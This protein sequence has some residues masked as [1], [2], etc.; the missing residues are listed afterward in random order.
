MATLTTASAAESDA[1]EATGSKLSSVAADIAKLG[2]GTLLAALFNVALVFVVPRLISVE[3]YGY[4]KLFGLYAGYV[5]FLHFGYADGALVRWAGRTW[6]DFHHE[7]RPALN[8][9]FWQHVI[10]LVPLCLI[11]ALVL[12]G[13]LRFAIIAVAVYSL[14]MNEA[15]LLQFGL[16]DAK[17]FWPVAISTAAPPAIFFG[18]ILLWGL[19]W[20]SDYRDVTAFYIA[21]W[22]MVLVF[23]LI[24][25]KPWSGVRVR[26]SAKQQAKDWLRIGWPIVVANT[27]VCL[28]QFADRIAVSWAATI[29]NFAQYSL[30][31]SA[32]AVP[33]TAIA[34]CSNVFF[35]HLAGVTSGGRKR[36]YRLSSRLILIAWAALLPYYF[37]L[38][39]FVGHFLPKYTASLQYAR[40]LLL[41]MPF[42]A[43]VQ[44]L[45][46][47]LAYLSG[48]QRSFLAQTLA[49]LVLS[50]GITSFVA[51][52][53]GSL[54][55][56][57]AAQVGILAAWWL[58]NEWNL[59]DLTDGY[60]GG[61]IGFF[62]IY[63]VASGCYW[64]VTGWTGQP[65]VLLSLIYY[66]LFGVLL[67]VAG[68]EEL[69]SCV[70]VV[71]VKMGL[72]RDTFVG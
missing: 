67:S 12:H 14:I 59:R 54:R 22:L 41:G 4:W 24:W 38:D 1:R 34:A 18:V 71:L 55:V 53:V 19:K 63:G 56:V 42:L 61:W 39:I 26:V 20:R 25:T 47:N 43:A 60:F 17:I 3:D 10:M 65:A 21:G 36:M 68:P 50:V 48:R 57:A 8:Y 33:I 69:R 7:I 40:V 28:I 27:A 35:S 64:L 72:H 52:H 31:G 15:T 37:A 2:S 9:L 23:L 5:G 51:F 58:F 32:M 66:A 70:K 62:G 46:T 11:A 6:G 16:Q 30:A 49:V 13:P 44:I 29:Q 45:Q